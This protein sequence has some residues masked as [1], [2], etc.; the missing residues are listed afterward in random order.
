MAHRADPVLER[1]LRQAAAWALAAAIGVG[2]AAASEPA[3]AT[4]P[5]PAEDARWTALLQRYVDSRGLVAYARWKANAGDLRALH[6]YVAAFSAPAARPPSDAEKIAR[7]ADAYDATIVERVL[8]AYP[9]DGIRSIPN[10]F[11]ERTHRIGGTACSLD[12]IERAA[13]RLGGYRVHAALVCAARSCPPL[14]RRAW[15]ADDLR[16]HEEERMR[17]WFSRDDLFRF[18]PAGGV[19]YLSRY[20]DWYR[21]DFERDGIGAVLAAYAPERFRAWLSG[22]RFRIEYL[23]YDWRLNDQSPPGGAE[24]SPPGSVP[25]GGE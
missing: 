21:A 6:D 22:G 17:T 13:V 1:R 5:G 16:A 24:Q 7:L 14:D 23:E 12:A 9:L 15:T 10:V 19:A 25:G 3:L 11:T 2:R 4:F 20:F 8:D 18:D